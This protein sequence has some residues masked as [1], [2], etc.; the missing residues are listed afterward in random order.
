[1]IL[2]LS[3]KSIIINV[4]LLI[5]FS[6]ILSPYTDTVKKNYNL[7]EVFQSDADYY[8]ENFLKTGSFQVHSSALT[9]FSAYKLV[10]TTNENR[11]ICTRCELPGTDCSEPSAL[12]CKP[13]P[14]IEEN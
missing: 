13:N 12:D 5:I 11:Q 10:Y 3:T 14:E 1:M 6:V 9:S 4:L 7:I 8:E 2:H